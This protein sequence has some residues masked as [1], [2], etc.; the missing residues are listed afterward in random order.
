MKIH[1]LKAETDHHYEVVD[2]PAQS[3]ISL[4]Y[5]TD[6]EDADGLDM[7]Y[8]PLIQ[9]KAQS[10]NAASLS[11]SALMYITY[12][13]FDSDSCWFNNQ[14][15]DFKIAVPVADAGPHIQHCDHI[16]A[17]QG[18]SAIHIGSPKNERLYQTYMDLL[19]WAKAQ[20]YRLENW[21]VEEWLISPM[22]TNNS[23][24]WMIRVM[25]P[26][27]G[28]RIQARLAGRSFSLNFLFIRRFFKGKHAPW[29]H[30]LNWIPA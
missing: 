5:R 15:H 20:G 3:V 24:L 28:T 21:S 19:K 25:I 30:V 4:R 23:D 29:G 9:T 26:F 17:F 1:D 16:P 10:V 13:H 11:I 18:V 6:F 7:D 2:R 14:V 27:R 22:I 12:D 8:L